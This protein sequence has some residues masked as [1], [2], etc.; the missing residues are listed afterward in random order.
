[1]SSVLIYHVENNKSKEN[2]SQKMRRCVQTFDW[3]CIYIYCI[4]I[5]Y[6]YQMQAV[7][8]TCCFPPSPLLPISTW[9]TSSR[10]VPPYVPWFC[11]RFLPDSQGVF[12]LPP[13]HLFLDR[14]Q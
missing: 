9:P 2:T 10:W 5:M 4:C 12:F 6:I 1:M 14:K 13:S 3:Y 8:N 7:Y 11:L